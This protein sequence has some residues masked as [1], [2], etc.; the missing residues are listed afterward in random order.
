M[1]NIKHVLMVMVLLS[2]FSWNGAWCTEVQTDGR[3]DMGYQILDKNP[4][5]SLVQRFNYLS[6]EQFACTQN[7]RKAK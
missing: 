2:Y 7:D 1:C 6:S 5:I 4:S 3:M